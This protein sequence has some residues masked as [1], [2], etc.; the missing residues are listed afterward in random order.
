MGTEVAPTIYNW[1][2]TRSNV[3]NLLQPITQV[4]IVANMPF[5]EKFDV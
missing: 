2:I 5:A 3:Y 4:G 1:N